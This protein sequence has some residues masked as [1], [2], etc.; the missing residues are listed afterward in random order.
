MKYNLPIK[1]HK[2]WNDGSYITEED[3]AYGKLDDKKL[4]AYFEMRKEGFKHKNALEI[5]KG[6]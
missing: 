5:A 1:P 2:K 4:K 3:E 6:L